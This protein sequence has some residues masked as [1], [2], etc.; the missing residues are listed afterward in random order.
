VTNVVEVSARVHDKYA[1]NDPLL[2]CLGSAPTA[3]GGTGKVTAK[4]SREPLL[5]QAQA[6]AQ[7][8][9]TAPFSVNMY[10][11]LLLYSFFCLCKDVRFTVD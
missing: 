3:G 2:D 4:V 6:Q 10:V 11:L 7:A 9:K 8:P 5:A 1:Q